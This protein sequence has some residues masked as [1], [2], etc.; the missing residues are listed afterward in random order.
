MT[1]TSFVTFVSGSFNRLSY[2]RCLLNNH[3]FS[4][5]ILFFG[6]I[7]PV[8]VGG[9]VTGMLPLALRS[10]RVYLFSDE[11]CAITGLGGKFV[12]LF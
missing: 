1:Q 3:L 10:I 7:I 12:Y 8:P 11:S 6:E 9:V 2:V 4:S 5:R